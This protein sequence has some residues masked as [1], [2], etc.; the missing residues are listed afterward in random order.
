MHDLID[1][2]SLLIREQLTVEINKETVLNFG[3]K[4]RIRVT[5]KLMGQTI[6][7]DTCDLAEL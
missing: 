2:I 7:E 6:S 4:E 3:P 5:L 1:V